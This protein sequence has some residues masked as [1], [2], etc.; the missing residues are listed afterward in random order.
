MKQNRKTE[1][2]T[3]V[4]L[5]MDGVIAKFFERFASDNGVKKVD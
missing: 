4:F 1:Q 5:D 2:M 3:T